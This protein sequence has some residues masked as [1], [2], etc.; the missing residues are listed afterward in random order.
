MI[1][2]EEALAREF[3]CARATVNRALRDLAEAGVL[4]RRRKAGTRVA[5]QPGAAGD[6]GDSG[7]PAGGRGARADAMPIA[8]LE[9]RDGGG[10]ACRSASA[11][12][13]AGGADAAL[14]TLHLA[15][16]RP[17]PAMRSAG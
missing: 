17:V 11:G 1:P 4:E 13:A 3:G 12:P 9:R 7:D 10:A 8:L 16:G 14:E 5:L 15:D 2:G 6:A